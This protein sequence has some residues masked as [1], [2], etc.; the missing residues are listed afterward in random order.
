MSEIIRA[1]TMTDLAPLITLL[2]RSWLVK[3]APEPELPFE[4]VQAFAMQDPAHRCAETMWTNFIVAD[5]DGRVAGMC[6]VAGNLIAAIHVDPAP[7]RR[8]IGARL[9]DAAEAR[10]FKDFER[11]RLEVLAFNQ[12]AQAFYR[13]RGW[14][15]HRRLTLVECGV[16]VEG[17]EMIKEQG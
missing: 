13:E 17:I 6:H 8:G 2:R 15:D 11:A 9:M 14:R 3:F 16:S 5:A 1:A 12:G 4:V 10:I 7:K